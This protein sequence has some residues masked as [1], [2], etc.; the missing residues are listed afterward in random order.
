MLTTHE[1]A[2]EEKQLADQEGNAPCNANPVEDD[3]LVLGGHEAHG[4]GFRNALQPHLQDAGAREGQH[5]NGHANGHDPE[6]PHL[7]ALCPLAVG[8]AAAQRG[9]GIA[10]ECDHHQHVG[11]IESQVTVCSGDL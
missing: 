1:E 7:G 2:R 4:I 6:A 8:N 11:P 3:E 9:H 5:H 10:D